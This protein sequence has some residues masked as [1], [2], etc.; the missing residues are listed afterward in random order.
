MI[1][2]GKEAN[3]QKEKKNFRLNN[4]CWLFLSLFNRHLPCLIWFY[5]SYNLWSSSVVSEFAVLNWVTDVNN[6]AWYSSSWTKSRYCLYL[7]QIMMN[8][9]IT[10]QRDYTSSFC[11]LSSA[12]P[13]KKPNCW[14][15]AAGNE[16]LIDTFCWA[17]NFANKKH[18]YVKSESCL[19]ASS[20]FCFLIIHLYK[21]SGP[22][23]RR[24]KV[25]WPN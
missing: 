22:P 15:P 7:K 20:V 21:E 14:E 23:I 19:E 10:K 8:K 4:S 5:I 6:K 2:L 24:V 16:T 3:I 17:H 13:N 11:R 25:C 9:S 12:H 18:L 1:T